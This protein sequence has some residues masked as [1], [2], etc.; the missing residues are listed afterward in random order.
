MVA[1]D[2]TE[3]EP[4]NTAHTGEQSL[5]GRH[6]SLTSDVSTENKPRKQLFENMLVLEIFAGSSNLTIEIRRA[7]LRGVAVD[8]TVRRAKSLK[9]PTASILTPTNNL[10]NLKT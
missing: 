1:E 8:K 4:N 5:D 3:T 6:N 10:Q 2:I 9:H 7:N